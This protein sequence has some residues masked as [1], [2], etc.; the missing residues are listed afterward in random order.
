VI[1]V[2]RHGVFGTERHELGGQALGHY[3]G[4]GGLLDHLTDVVQR[5]A[6]GEIRASGRVSLESHLLG[7][8]AEQARLSGAVIEMEGF[9]QQA[10]RAAQKQC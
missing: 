5:Q 3:G 1:E 10:R 8:A 6:P 4:D 7:F 9:R 2:S